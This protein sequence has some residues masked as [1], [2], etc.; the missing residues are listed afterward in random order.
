MV[1]DTCHKCLENLKQFTL[2]FGFDCF[3]YMKKTMING[4]F[5]KECL[6]TGAG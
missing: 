1:D 4:F 3:L 2:H 5:S 6:I